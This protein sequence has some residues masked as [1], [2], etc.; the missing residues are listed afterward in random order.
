VTHANFCPNIE[1]LDKKRFIPVEWATKITRK[2]PVWINI[3]SLQR[4]DLLGSIVQTINAQSVSIVEVKVNQ[5][6]ALDS[7]Y[8]VR[9]MVNNL[10]DIQSILVNL[11][12]IKE[13]LNVERAI[14]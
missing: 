6:Q 8:L 3:T 11:K 12:K 1:A 10:E 9:I 7:Q 5:N 14:V 13:I 2:Y 4:H